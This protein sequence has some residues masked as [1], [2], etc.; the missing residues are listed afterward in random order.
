MLRVKGSSMCE[1]KEEG[2]AGSLPL[3]V[4]S[5]STASAALRAKGPTLS[6][7]DSPW[8]SV[9]YSHAGCKGSELGMDSRG[10]N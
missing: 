4:S 8:F 3:M 5:T 10:L 9:P 7:K 2:S 1:S 6:C